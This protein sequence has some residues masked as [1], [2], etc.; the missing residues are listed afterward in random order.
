MFKLL[1]RFFRRNQHFFQQITPLQFR[2]SILIYGNRV[3]PHRY[4]RGSLR[5]LWPTSVVQ[6]CGCF[7]QPKVS[8]S[9]TVSAFLIFKPHSCWWLIS[10]ALLRGVVLAFQRQTAGLVYCTHLIMKW[11]GRCKRQIDYK[12]FSEYLFLRAGHPWKTSKYPLRQRARP[13]A[14]GVFLFSVSSRRGGAHGHS[15]CGLCWGGDNR[16]GHKIAGLWCQT[17]RVRLQ[18]SK[19][20]FI[21]EEDGSSGR[22]TTG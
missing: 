6:E 19:M 16:G 21:S 4:N 2:G 20:L 7:P 9:A 15:D 13:H 8:I 12:L 14:R 5:S 22:W 17:N 1:C 10:A 18:R 11:K 3:E